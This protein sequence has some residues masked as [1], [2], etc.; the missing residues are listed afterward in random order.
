MRIL[1]Q[2]DNETV[3]SPVE[4]ESEVFRKTLKS[5]GRIKVRNIGVESSYTF[6]TSGNLELY[7]RN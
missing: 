2:K 7:L 1:K 4:Q 6:Y 3:I 5:V